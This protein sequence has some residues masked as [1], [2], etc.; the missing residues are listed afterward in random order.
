[1]SLFLP[2]TKFLYLCPLFSISYVYT[3]GNLFLN[4]Q[5][6]NTEAERGRIACVRAMMLTLFHIPI[7]TAGFACSDVP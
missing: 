3:D 1:M 2:I 6:G 4:K 5:L 7:S